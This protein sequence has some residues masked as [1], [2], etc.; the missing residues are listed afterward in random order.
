MIF[1]SSLVVLI[2]FLHGLKYEVNL[3]LELL[4]PC[5]EA[6]LARVPLLVQYQHLCGLQDVLPHL[7]PRHRHLVSD[8]LHPDPLPVGNAAV[9]SLV[10][11]EA[12]SFHRQT[13]VEEKNSGAAGQFGQERLAAG[14]L[15]DPEA[16]GK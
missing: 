6:L 16:A 7:Q 13:F 12:G 9:H 5:E 14:E 15:F 8:W 4:D 3:V 1:F 11:V 10:R 2:T